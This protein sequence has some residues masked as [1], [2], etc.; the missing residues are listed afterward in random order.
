M[1]QII[2][3]GIVLFFLYLFSVI[4]VCILIIASIKIKFAKSSTFLLLLHL[5]FVNLFRL[6]ICL[7]H[8]I[9]EYFEGYLYPNIQWPLCVEITFATVDQLTGYISAMNHFSVSFYRYLACCN[10]LLYSKLN[11]KWIKTSMLI[12]IWM[13]GATLVSVPLCV[14]LCC[15]KIYHYHIDSDELDIQN[16]T[17]HNSVNLTRNITLIVNFTTIFFTFWFLFKIRQ[18]LNEVGVVVIQHVQNDDKTRKKGKHIVL[19][20]FFIN[21]S[22]VLLC[23]FLFILQFIKITDDVITLVFLMYSLNAAVDAIV[24]FCFNGDLK[25]LLKSWFCWCKC[26]SVLLA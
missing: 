8:N 6:L 3:E 5:Q 18:R 2:L 25:S 23:L 10:H 13:L 16:L 22:F 1:I 24:I 11:V 15:T 21:I 4:L 26:T 19:Q 17:V 20:I 7:S 12:F 9:P 14:G